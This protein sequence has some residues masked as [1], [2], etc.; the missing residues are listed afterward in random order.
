VRTGQLLARS[1]YYNHC[2][3]VLSTLL[4]TGNLSELPPR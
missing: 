3:T 4:L 2:W 1:R